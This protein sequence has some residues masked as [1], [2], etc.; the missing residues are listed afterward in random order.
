MTNSLNKVLQKR[1]KMSEKQQKCL[2]LLEK[3]TFFK[4]ISKKS[5]KTLYKWKML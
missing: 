3:S 2:F 1:L 4:K 5:Q